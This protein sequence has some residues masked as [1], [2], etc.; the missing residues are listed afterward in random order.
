MFFGDGRPLVKK[1][2][3]KEKLQGSGEEGE[4]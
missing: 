4:S 1:E 2:K 3:L